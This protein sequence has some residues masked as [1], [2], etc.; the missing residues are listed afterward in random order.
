MVNGWPFSQLYQ[1]RLIS[2]I[3][4]PTLFHVFSLFF[5]IVHWIVHVF[6]GRRTRSLCLASAEFCA[7]YKK[8]K[9]ENCTRSNVAIFRC[10]PTTYY[11]SDRYVCVCETCLQ[12][13]IQIG[14]FRGLFS[15]VFFFWFMNVSTFI[16]LL[17][18]SMT[19]GCGEVTRR[20]KNT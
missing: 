13:N 1:F 11:M 4:N 17:A 18:R 20:K 6:W 14:N 10:R 16:S 7:L 19:D 5:S 2:A 12:Q 15:S 9:H 3:G 8:K